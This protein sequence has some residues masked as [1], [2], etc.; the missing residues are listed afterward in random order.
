[1]NWFVM[2]CRNYCQLLIDLMMVPKYCLDVALSCGS[3]NDL[4]WQS[5][6]TSLLYYNHYFTASVYLIKTVSFT[7][8]FVLKQSVCNLNF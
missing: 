3:L 6:D 8:D 1:M 5:E 2:F 4:L 7:S